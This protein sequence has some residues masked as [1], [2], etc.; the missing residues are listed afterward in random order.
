MADYTPDEGHG[1]RPTEV[2]GEEGCQ[3]AVEGEAH[4]RTPQVVV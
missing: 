3:L 1:S 2:S 4:I